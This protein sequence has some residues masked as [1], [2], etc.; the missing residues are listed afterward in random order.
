MNLGMDE[1]YVISLKRHETRRKR[2]HHLLYNNLKV[3]YTIIDSIDNKEYNL[4]PNILDKE[5]FDPSG[6]LTKGVLCCALSHQKAWKQFLDSGKEVAMFLEDDIKYTKYIHNFNFEQFRKDLD[7][8]ENWGCCFIGKYV[9]NIHVED[10]IKG[11]IYYG[12]PLHPDQFAAHAYILNRKSAQWYLDNYQKIKYA[13]DIRLDF[14]PFKL[15]STPKSIFKQRWP[16]LSKHH[17]TIATNPKYNWLEEFLHFTLE[18]GDVVDPLRNDGIMGDIINKDLPI[19][20]T[21]DDV[22]RFRKYSIKGKT[23]TFF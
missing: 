14:S 1:I 18:D 13:I 3:D 5:F 20:F 15:L 10:H 23:F 8:I 19:A 17:K 21:E 22:L 7:S 2:V 12:I 11:E 4:D 16:E 9:D 6:W